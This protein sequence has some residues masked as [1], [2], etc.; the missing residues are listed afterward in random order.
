VSKV[1]PK[2]T[3]ATA[4]AALSILAVGALH[5]VG[6]ELSDTEQGALATVFVFAAGYVKRG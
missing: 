5:R 2:V 3:A 6:V 4:A 1:N